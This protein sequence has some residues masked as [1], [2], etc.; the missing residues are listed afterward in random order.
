MIEII[1]FVWL[2]VA[3]FVVSFLI[4]EWHIRYLIVLLSLF[5]IYSIF[6]Y[7]FEIFNFISI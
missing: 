7:S 4:R 6:R 1:V 5:C 3:Y 2:V